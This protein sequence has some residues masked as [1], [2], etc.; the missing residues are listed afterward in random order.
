MNQL[1]EVTQSTAS[2]AEELA[3]TSQMLNQHAQELK[4]LIGFFRLG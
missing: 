3:S 2:S 4:S 1:N